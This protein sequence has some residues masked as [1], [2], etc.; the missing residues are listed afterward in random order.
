MSNLLHGIIHGKT[1]QL[2]EDPGI[3]EGQPVQVVVQPAAP[4]KRWGDGLRRCAGSMADDPDFDAIM[5]EIQD[6]RKRAKFREVQ[7]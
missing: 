6:E 7:E 5:Q 2:D 1:I 4:P 3:G